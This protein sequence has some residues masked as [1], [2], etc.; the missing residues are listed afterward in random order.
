MPDE[1]VHCARDESSLK[2]LVYNSCSKPT[3]EGGPINPDLVEIGAAVTVR[4]GQR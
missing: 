4:R 1:N 3:P 2:Y